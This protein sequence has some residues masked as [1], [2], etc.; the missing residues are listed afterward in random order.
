MKVG[1][2]GVNIKPMVKLNG[3]AKIVA[4]F[5]ADSYYANLNC[6]RNS[7]NSNSNL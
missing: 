4:R 7:G 6:S 3:N 5:Y 2:S 1:N